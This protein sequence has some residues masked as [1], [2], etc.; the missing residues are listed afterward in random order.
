ME[1]RPAPPMNARALLLALATGTLYLA[2]GAVFGT[3]MLT[4]FEKP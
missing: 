2:S 3:G 4:E 1:R